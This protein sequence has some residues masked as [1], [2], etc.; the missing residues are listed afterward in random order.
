MTARPLI[1]VVEQLI[2]LV[3][4]RK[5]LDQHADFSSLSEADHFHELT[6]ADRLAKADPGNAS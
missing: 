4:P 3:H 1:A 2:R 6:I 5:T